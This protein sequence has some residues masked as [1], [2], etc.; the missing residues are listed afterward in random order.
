MTRLIKVLIF[1]A[2]CLC[3]LALVSFITVAT[4]ANLLIVIPAVA[5]AAYLAF[6]TAHWTILK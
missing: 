1:A 6:S 2:S 5:S 3:L 4:H